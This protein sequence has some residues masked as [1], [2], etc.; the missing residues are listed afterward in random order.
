LSAKRAATTSYG[1]YGGTFSKMGGRPKTHDVGGSIGNISHI[2]GA[3]TI[4]HDANIHIVEKRNDDE[5]YENIPGEN[6]QTL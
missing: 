1:N 3:A 5:L 6:H 2:S 4:D